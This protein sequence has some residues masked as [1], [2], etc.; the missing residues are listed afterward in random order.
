MSDKI[1]ETDSVRAREFGFTSDKFDGY[2]WDLSCEGRIMISFIVSKQKGRGNLNRLFEAIW[3]KGLRV[4]VP[5]PMGLLRRILAK[6]GFKIFLEQE[7][8]VWER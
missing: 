1:I 8:E 7:S 3:A 4:A 5:T 2:L 6:K